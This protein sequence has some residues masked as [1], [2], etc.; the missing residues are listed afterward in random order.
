[1]FPVEIALSQAFVDGQVMFTGILRDLTD[2]KRA[3]AEIRWRASLLELSH[4]AVIVWRMDKGIIYWNG[5]A[6]EL[7]G[8]TSDEAAG[9]TTHDLLGSEYPCSTEEFERLLISAGSWQGELNQRTKSGDAV[10]VESR[11]VTMRDDQGTMLVMETN[12]DVTERHEIHQRVCRLAEQLE[13]RVDQRTKELMQSQEHLRALAAELSLIEQ[14]ERKRLAT[15][16]HDHLAQLLVLGRLQ[17][18]QAKPTG[19]SQASGAALIDKTM[20]VLDE[21]LQYTRTLVADLSP[22]VLRDFG[23]HAVLKWLGE[24]MRRHEL[25]VLIQWSGN[26]QLNLRE[27]QNVLL[28]QSVR[29][30]LI[31]VSKHAGCDTAVVAVAQRDGHLCIEVRDDGQG[32]DPEM[33]DASCTPLSSK[34]GLFS[35]KERMIAMGGRFE[36]HSSPGAGTR[37][38]L[39]LPILEA[40]TAYTFSG[41]SGHPSSLASRLSSTNDGAPSPLHDPL[42][43]RVLLVDDHTMVRQG[44]RSLLEGYTDIEVVGEAGN[45]KDAVAMVGELVPQVVIMDV[46]MPEMDGVEATAR[47]TAEEPATIVIGLSMHNSGHYEE[48]MKAAGARAYLS[49][50]SISDHL[51]NTI[52]ACRSAHAG[53]EGLERPAVAPPLSAEAADLTM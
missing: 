22:P 45:G 42:K 38:T 24:H 12:R 51:H 48:R 43:V 13:Q 21:A 41:S 39:T 17:L 50:D 23:L 26:E 34:F 10:I 32:F 46:N 5:G 29:E 11:Q 47:I 6:T 15:D 4:E 33:T 20:G 7:Y 52:L 28:F 8:W 53:A 9:R 31:N 27:E 36:M 44:L 35:I 19:A 49:K 16:L 30:L 18:S 3:E 14:R 1:L 37:A 2:R 25:E 40:T